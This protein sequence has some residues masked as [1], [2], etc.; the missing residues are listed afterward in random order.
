MNWI[1]KIKKGHRF[2]DKHGNVYFLEER[3]RGLF[4]DDNGKNYYI[5]C[6]ELDKGRG[7]C[8]FQENSISVSFRF[9]GLQKFALI[10]ENKIEFINK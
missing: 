5:K 2:K 8:M 10:T 6:S 9:L 4:A 7:E 1:E 3:K